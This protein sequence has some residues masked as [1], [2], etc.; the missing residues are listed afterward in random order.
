MFAGDEVETLRSLVSKLSL[1]E[2]QY[3]DERFDNT[4]MS[5]SM[6]R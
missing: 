2:K 4:L 5:L 6:L 3:E 1:N